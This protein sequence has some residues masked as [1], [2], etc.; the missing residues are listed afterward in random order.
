MLV[1]RGTLTDRLNQVRSRKY[2]FLRRAYILA[3]SRFFDSMSIYPSIADNR[4]EGDILLPALYIVIKG[5]AF[6]LLFSSSP[7]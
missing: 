3:Q 7:S 6:Y 4:F 2:M 1:I 5:E